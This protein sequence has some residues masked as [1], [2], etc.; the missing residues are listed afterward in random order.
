[1]SVKPVVRSAAMTASCS[2]DR[3]NSMSL[4]RLFVASGLSAGVDVPLDEAQAH[5][6]RHVM[7]RPDGA[8]LLL[9]NGRD[10][11]W[12]GTLEGR[13]RK[14][15]V[16]RLGERTREQTVEPDIWLCFAPLKRARIDYVAEKA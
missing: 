10:G 15:A 6:L 9:F 2:D 8:P 7:R 14:A 16:A 1:M 5:Y 12:R 4:S 11:E 3:A 13:G